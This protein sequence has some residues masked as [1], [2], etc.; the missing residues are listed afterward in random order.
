MNNNNV[1][2]EALYRAQSKIETVVL[3]DNG[4][5]LEFLKNGTIII[6]ELDSITIQFMWGHA[7]YSVKL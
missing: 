7:P 5:I 1:K 3:A 4:A 6:K 2:A